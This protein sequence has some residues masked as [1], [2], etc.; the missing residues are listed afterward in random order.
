MTYA[1]EGDGYDV[2]EG[3]IRGYA[4]GTSEDDA[5]KIILSQISMLD[6]LQAAINTTIK[7]LVGDARE[8]G[9]SWAKI[10]D[11]LST[12]KQAAQQRYGR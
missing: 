11:A 4:I 8:G 6:E 1:E 3:L 9:A 7:D 12:T 2:T 10:G 5:T